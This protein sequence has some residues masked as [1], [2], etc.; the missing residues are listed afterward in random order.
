MLFKQED[1]ITESYDPIQEAADILNE[2]VYLE[3]K[4]SILNP[5]AIPV[6]ENTRIGAHVVSFED[7]DRLSEDAGLSYL[8]SMQSIAEANDIS[9]DE[10]AV[11]VPE[12]KI[13]ADPEVVNELSN[14][15]IAPINTNNP[16][17]QFIEACIDAAIEEDTSLLENLDKILD[18]DIVLLEILDT[19]EKVDWLKSK[20]E[21]RTR[22]ASRLKKRIDQLSNTIKNDD[23]PN[24]KAHAEK[25]LNKYK[26]EYD[27]LNKKHTSRIYRK[28]ADDKRFGYTEKEDRIKLRALARDDEDRKARETGKRKAKAAEAESAKS[29]VQ[30]TLNKIKNSTPAKY[31]AEAISSLRSK[32]KSIKETIDNTSPE[33]RTIFQKILNLITGAIDKLA[34]L[35]K[36]KTESEGKTSNTTNNDK[37]NSSSSSVSNVP[38]LAASV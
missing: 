30:K 16:V 33:K 19:Q 36:K 28:M 15:I 25:Q 13:I 7:V 37:N 12:W 6:V 14:V 18:E 31:I 29:F 21:E 9:M 26:A 35:F 27:Q 38:M 17:Y 4:E 32:Y 34:N 10:L 20:M 23:D 11:A 22:T 1:L 3:E 24:H 2:S 5:I 8:D